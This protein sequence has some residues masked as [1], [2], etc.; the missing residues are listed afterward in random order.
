MNNSLTPLR[1]HVQGHKHWQVTCIKG[2]M[3][4]PERMYTVVS[5]RK[6]AADSAGQSGD[7]QGLS[8]IEEAGSESVAELVDE[9]QFYEAEAIGGVQDAPGPDVAEVHT[10]EFPEDDVPS[11]YQGQDQ[12]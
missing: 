8:T 6:Q 9:G 7:D 5:N 4:K 3:T 12:D 11:E 10:K 1:L 2:R